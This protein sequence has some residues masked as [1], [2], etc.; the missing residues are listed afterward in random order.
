MPKNESY[1]YDDSDIALYATD[2]Y[3]GTDSDLDDTERYTSDIDLSLFTGAELDFT[4]DGID[5]TDDL[6]L[7]LYKRRDSS[8]SGNELAWKTRLTA[9]N[10]GTESEYHYSIPS[11][12]G[13]GHYRFGMVSSGST[14]TFE[15]S[16]ALRRWRRTL[17]TT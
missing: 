5:T 12:Y 13:V 10:D 2:G 16:V 17:G 11:E 1:L 15:I 3:G 4:F 9:S 14:T 8:W 6:Y 7:Y